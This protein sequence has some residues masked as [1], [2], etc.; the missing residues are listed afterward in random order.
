[1]LRITSL[2]S[3][4]NHCGSLW[5][6]HY[7][8]LTVV[9]VSWFGLSNEV[10]TPLMWKLDTTMWWRQTGSFRVNCES[11]GP[12]DVRN[13]RQC[14]EQ[15]PFGE[16]RWNACMCMYYIC[17]EVCCVCVCLGV[18][19]RERETKTKRRKERNLCSSV[20]EREWNW[21]CVCTHETHFTHFSS[22]IL[23]PADKVSEKVAVLWQIKSALC[24][25]SINLAFPLK[26]NVF[27]LGG[28]CPEQ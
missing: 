18:C 9:Q 22:Y 1:M 3:L 7:C 11:A 24:K 6:I 14:G 16:V 8:P 4:G 13:A 28:N 15:Q 5:V 27:V 19:V 2:F 10:N 25:A 20:T 26:W 23:H 12:F 21:M 17:T